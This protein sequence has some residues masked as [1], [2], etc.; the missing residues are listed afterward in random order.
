MDIDNFLKEFDANPHVHKLFKD[1]K[2]LR[3]V[4]VEFKGVIGL[5]SAKRQIVS[6]IKKFI[7]SKSNNGGIHKERKHCLLLGPPG[8]GKTTVCKILCKIWIAM[9][10]IGKNDAG[11]KAVPTFNK[12]QDELIRRQKKEIEEVRTR[13]TVAEK[14][15]NSVVKVA[16]ASQRDLS[17]LI[18]YK[19]VIQ[20]KDYNQIYTDLTSS[21]EI[22]RAASGA[23][24]EGIKNGVDYSV[25]MNS[26]PEKTSYSK[27]KDLPLFT[28]KK[29]DVVSKYVGGTPELC[30][31]AMNKALGGVAFFDECYNLCSPSH[32]LGTD[33]GMDALTII[34][35]YMDLESDN[36]IVVFGGYKQQ[37]IDNLFAAQP[38]LESRFTIKIEIEGYTPEEMGSI[39]IY[40]LSSINIRIVNEKIKTEINEL[41]K[42][43]Y[44]LFKFYGRDMNTLAAHTKTVLSGDSYEMVLK[45]EKIPVISVLKD[46]APAY[47]ALE[48]F[49]TN[50]IGGEKK[51]K[52]LSYLEQ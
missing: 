2:Y 18:K 25:S 1:S 39:F 46:S 22:I 29:K 16:N 51:Q 7:A 24:K 41:I 43:N 31:N 13:L 44:K 26:N 50:S 48:I 11:S 27:D 21:C 32:S 33:Y 30:T 47:Q 37:I 38:G 19:N 17:L 10:Y 9:G 3:E 14:S 4:L 40:Q 6:N 52:S 20:K 23:V 36:L 15:V 12:L 45:K 28:F 34:N 5:R 42:N 8:T 49:K 35:E